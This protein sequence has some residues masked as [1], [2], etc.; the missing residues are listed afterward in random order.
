[1]STCPLL[2]LHHAVFTADLP[3]SQ[4]K[5][6]AVIP[7]SYTPRSW[8]FSKGNCDEDY[9]QPNYLSNRVG[10]TGTEGQIHCVSRHFRSHPWQ[11]YFWRC[12]SQTSCHTSPFYKVTLTWVP[13]KLV[14][15]CLQGKYSYM[16]SKVTCEGDTASPWFSRE[17][18]PLG[19]NHHPEKKPEAHGEAICRQSNWPA[20][21]HQPS[22]V[23]VRKRS[24][25]PQSQMP[26][27]C[28]SLRDPEWKLPL[29]APEPMRSSNIR[30][31]WPSDC[32]DQWSDD[33][34]DLKPRGQPQWWSRIPSEDLLLSASLF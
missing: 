26:T 16:T 31:Q 30:S 14:G 12:P 18:A 22:A 1:M 13:P 5:T 17:Q 10:F 11:L 8:S 28:N 7:T 24:R 21:Q 32:C 19:L 6:K 20:R 34:Y 29:P 27:D 33:H 4:N 15:W 2:C 25:W 23:Q 3:E 9:F